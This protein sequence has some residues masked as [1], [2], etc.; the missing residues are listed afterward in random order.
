MGANKLAV[1]VV[2]AVERAA[3]PEPAFWGLWRRLKDDFPAWSLLPSS[4]YTPGAWGYLGVDFVSGFRQNPST[5]RSFALLDGVDEATFDAVAALAALNARRQEQMLRAVIITYLTVPIS[6][7]A[8]VAEVMGDS[9][10]ALVRQNA[11]LVA[12][13]AVTLAVGPISYLL[14]NWRARQIVGVLDLIRIERG[15]RG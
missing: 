9:I 7:T 2:E 6:V 14:S 11:S 1:E 10:G 3:A 15:V 13:I 5:R 12:G 4:L 8:L